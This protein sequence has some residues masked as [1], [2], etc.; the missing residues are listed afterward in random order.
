MRNLRTM[1][2]NLF[3]STEVKKIL[4]VSQRRITHLVDKGLI[5]PVQNAKGA[6][7]KR[8]Y[9]YLNLLDFSLAEILFNM[10]LGIHLVKRIL[11]DLKREGILELWAE[12]FEGHFTR[13]AKE[14]SQWAKDGMNQRD[15]WSLV[16]SNG[17]KKI[18][19]WGDVEEIKKGLMPK[20]QIGSFFYCFKEDG[21]N[22]MTIIPWDLK[23]SIGVPFLQKEIFESKGIIVINLG[24]IKENLDKMVSVNK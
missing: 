22:K 24:E 10:E 4:S 23:F 20:T 19:D 21:T 2:K 12:N 17:N 6:G 9:S 18:I 8:L 1:E 15:G 3:T 13:L 16:L 11:S 14:Y 5:V 7:S